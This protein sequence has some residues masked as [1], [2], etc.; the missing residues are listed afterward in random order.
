[1]TQAIKKNDDD[2]ND[3]RNGDMLTVSFLKTRTSE[4]W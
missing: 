3:D 1:M 2:D 4:K